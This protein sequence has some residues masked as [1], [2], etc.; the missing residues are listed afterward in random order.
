MPSHQL[1]SIPSLRQLKVQAKELLKDQRAGTPEACAKFKAHLPHLRAASDAEVRAGEFSLHHAQLVVAREYGFPS[2]PQLKS[3]LDSLVGGAPPKHR[4]FVKDLKYYVER[5][6]GLLTAYKTGERKSLRQVREW[7]PSASAEPDTK[8]PDGF[9]LEVAQ[10]VIARQHGFDDWPAFRNHIEAVA[11]GEKSEPFLDAFE[12][13][14]AG[15]RSKFEAL[16]REHPDLAKAS[17]TNGNTLLNLA[18]SCKRLEMVK[19]LLDAGADP[20]LANNHGWTPLHQAAYGFSELIE[21]LVSAGASVDAMARGDGG[22]PL[23]VALFWGNAKA[24]DQLAR[25]GVAPLNLRVAAGLG[26]LDLIEPFFDSQGRLKAEAGAH[27]EFHRPHGGFPAWNPSNDPQE[28]LDEALVWACKNARIEALEL[29]ISKGAN[30]DADPYRGT[31]LIF[32]ACHGRADLVRWLLAHGAGV[33]CLGTFGGPGY[34]EGVTALHLAAQFGCIEAAKVLVEAGSDLTIQDKCHQGRPLG[35]AMQGSEHVKNQG[36]D[37]P[38]V[39]EL[40]IRS[41]SKLPDTLRGSAEVQE[42][43]R[44]HGVPG[45]TK[46]VAN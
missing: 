37:Y 36:G 31:C 42:V 19:P 17:G 24:A 4:P 13:I 27:R 12:A 26:R 41:G 29:L 40:L 21:P 9:S 5:A 7:F 1:P 23:V 11:R 14:K 22:T 45:D 6:E 33:N 44:R 38:A 3:H 20:N 46:Q 18:A 28:I 16:L 34:G 25:H 10:S 43:L 32:A 30:I 35:W 8:A 2:W 39:V 15:D